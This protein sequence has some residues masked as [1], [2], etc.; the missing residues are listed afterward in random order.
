MD[1]LLLLFLSLGGFIGSPYDGFAI[2][3]FNRTSYMYLGDMAV[4][5][6]TCNGSYYCT[7]ETIPYDSCNYV[8]ISCV[9]GKDCLCL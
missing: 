9:R 4:S 1:S 6:L 7:N 8:Y 2:P 3:D 5:N